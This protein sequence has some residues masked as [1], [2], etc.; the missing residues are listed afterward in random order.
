MGGA[1]ADNV[2][3]YFYISHIT[4][5]LVEKT[6]ENTA[7]TLFIYPNLACGEQYGIICNVSSFLEILN[8]FWGS[9]RRVSCKIPYQRVYSHACLSVQCVYFILFFN[10]IFIALYFR[11]ELLKHKIVIV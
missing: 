7:C 3:E 10:H 2:M 9:G 5:Y 4:Q 6:L 8:Y 11:T 1:I